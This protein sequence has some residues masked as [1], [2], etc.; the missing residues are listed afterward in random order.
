MCSA[1]Y[2]RWFNSR[3]VSRRYLRM[4]CRDYENIFRRGIDRA[5]EWVMRL[6]SN[7]IMGACLLIAAV[8]FMVVSVTGALPPQLPKPEPVMTAQAATRQDLRES[9]Q[10]LRERDQQQAA[11]QDKFEVG[12]SDLAKEVVALKIYTADLSSRITL[13]DWKVGMILGIM[14]FVAADVGHRWI[15]RIRRKL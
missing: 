10:R 2:N 12:Q 11:R 7:A 5:R 14:V 6:K 4:L 13:V 8:G 9:E 15:E 3:E 1:G